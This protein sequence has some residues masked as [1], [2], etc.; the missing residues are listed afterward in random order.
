MLTGAVHNFGE[1]KKNPDKVRQRYL[2]S[3]FGPTAVATSGFR[4]I[5]NTMLPLF[6]MTSMNLIFSRNSF[7]ELLQKL[8]VKSFADVI[9]SMPFIQVRTFRIT[10]TL[11]FTMI[12]WAMFYIVWKWSIQAPIIAGK[13]KKK[14][15]SKE[16]DSKDIESMLELALQKVIV[17]IEEKNSTKNGEEDDFQKR[18]E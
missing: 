16:L 2:T 12:G 14:R 7:V 15:S 11:Y 18:Q 1:T 13:K 9:L 17:K 8:S 5:R 6:T 4:A 10:N 3:F